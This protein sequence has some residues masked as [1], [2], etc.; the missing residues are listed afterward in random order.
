MKQGLRIVLVLVLAVVVLFGFGKSYMTRVE[1]KRESV[2][3]LA[4]YE[5]ELKA[6]KSGTDS[7]SQTTPLDVMD[8]EEESQFKLRMQ[9]L[10]D[11]LGLV[12]SDLE[13]TFKEFEDFEDFELNLEE[14]FEELENIDFESDDWEENLGDTLG[15]WGVNFGDAMA[16][17][18]TSLGDSLEET[19]T[20]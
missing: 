13:E 11:E 7:N 5:E 20:D 4:S 8:K 1:A 19:F 15:A 10:A 9:E 6:G 18:G 14:T 2:R 16:E 12:E 3:R 17:F